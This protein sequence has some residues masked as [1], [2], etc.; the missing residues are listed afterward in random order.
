MEHKDARSLAPSAQ[1]ELRLKAVK[2]VLDGAKQVD[3]ASLYGITRQALGKWI[4]TYRRHGENGLKNRPQGR[5]R[6]IVLKQWQTD[7][8]V[9]RILDHQPEQLGLTET[10]WS[11]QSVGE[12]VQSLFDIKLSRWTIGRYL[13]LL[14]LSPPK[15]MRWLEEMNPQ[16]A[17]HWMKEEYPLIHKQAQK[18]KARIYWVLD[19]GIELSCPAEAGPGPAEASTSRCSDS[20]KMIAA[21]TNRGRFSFMIYSD[22]LASDI[23]L[24]FLHRLFLQDKNKRLY[25]IMQDHPVHRHTEVQ[26]FLASKEID[27]A[28]VPLSACRD[29]SKSNREHFTPEEPEITNILR[30]KRAS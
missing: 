25:L 15:P 5:P 14:G 20:R 30:Q 3:V 11:R 27:S 28:T 9:Q 7:I 18:N 22:R 17:R 2:A 8:L 21:I 19:T 24:E 10:L 1:E 12:L 6:G 16:K 4:Q 13:N 29:R 23:A 26:S